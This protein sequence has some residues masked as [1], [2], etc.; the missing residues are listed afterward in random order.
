MT[1]WHGSR[2]TA[3]SGQLALLLYCQSCLQ[4][5]QFTIYAESQTAGKPRRRT[6]ELAEAT[7]IHSGF[8]N[9]S[10]LAFQSMAG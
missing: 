10:M 4:E 9:C 2:G 8:A 1:P 6:P 3:F 7:G 5:F